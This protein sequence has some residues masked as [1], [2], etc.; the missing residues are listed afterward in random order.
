MPLVLVISSFVAGSRV[1]GGIA[2]FVLG[3]MKVDPVHVP[4][5]LFG[6]HPGWGPPGGTAVDAEVMAKMVEGI[7]ANG[8][9]GWADAVVTGHFSHPEQVAVACE[10]IGR[11]RTA[12]RGPGHQYS[13]DSPTVVVDPV[14][15]DEGPGLYIKPPVAE[16]LIH[17]LVP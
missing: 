5:C 6:R 10:V 15:G 17:D 7:E 1:G 13:S 4:T 11:I 3:P 8:L 16:A 14:M 9:F 12:P 2:P